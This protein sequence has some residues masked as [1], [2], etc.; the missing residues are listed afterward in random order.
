MGRAS[1]RELECFA[2]IAEH[3]NFSKAARHLNLTQPPL[4]RHIQSLEEKLGAKLFK[5]N[6]HA[7]SLTGAGV[8]FVEDARTILGH[9]DRASE[10]IRRAAQG[11]T[12]RLRLALIGALLD[13]KIVRLIQEFRGVYPNCQVQIMDLAP[14][15]Q[16]ASIKA[17]N[18]D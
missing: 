7:V 12:L 17:G 3:L 1:V 16:L 15:A 10:T 18:L 11:E 5:R 9:L 14:S 13:E 6:T 4:T 2:A 8:L